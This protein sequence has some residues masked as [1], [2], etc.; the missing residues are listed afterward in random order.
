[1]RVMDPFSTA[2][3]VVLDVDCETM[4]PV[5]NAAYN[6]AGELAKL[7]FGAL[8]SISAKA[9]DGKVIITPLQL[10]SV[11]RD[12]ANGTTSVLKL[13]NFTSC[14]SGQG[15]KLPESYDPSKLMPGGH[16]AVVADQIKK[17]EAPQE[18]QEIDD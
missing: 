10:A 4:L 14:N 18:P 8:G 5:W 3:R 17:D 12:A 13:T 6:R 7:T 15:V 9:S 1:M 2:D 16:S 11:V